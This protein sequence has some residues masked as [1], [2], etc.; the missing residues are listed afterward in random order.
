MFALPPMGSN[1]FCW[2]V[3]GELEGTF[4]KVPSNKSHP[5]TRAPSNK[6]RPLEKNRVPHVFHRVFHSFH[7]VFHR[8]CKSE[9]KR[10]KPRNFAPFADSLS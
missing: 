9:K 5:L 10:G 8:V 7:R 1:P 3:L 2:G 6:P 4:P